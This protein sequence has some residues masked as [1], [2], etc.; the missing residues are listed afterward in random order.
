M[1]GIVLTYTQRRYNKI[2][3]NLP[4]SQRYYRRS[5]VLIGCYCLPVGKYSPTFR[6]FILHS[7]QAVKE[8][9]MLPGLLDVEEGGTMT[10]RQDVTSQ[11]IL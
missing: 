2:Y 1:Q 10:N 11:K 7:L 9:S 3:N 8:K 4:L 5:D 6:N